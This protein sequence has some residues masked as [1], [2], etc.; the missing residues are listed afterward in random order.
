MCIIVNAE[1]QCNAKCW[2]IFV[3]TC[4]CKCVVFILWNLT[5]Y[6]LHSF[7]LSLIVVYR[8]REYKKLK[9]KETRRRTQLRKNKIQ[10]KKRIN[11]K[12]KQ[13][14]LINNYYR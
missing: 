8:N 10:N 14:A 1:K 2:Y 3:Y 12:I 6:I 9:I 7:S 11:I 5:S 13:T 4:L